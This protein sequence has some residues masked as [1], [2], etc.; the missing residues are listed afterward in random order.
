VRLTLWLAFLIAAPI[1]VAQQQ[2]S[3]VACPIVRDT[4]TVPCFLAEYDGELY[5]L[6]IQ[7]DIN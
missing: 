6:G 4:K 5:Y 1:L 2:R 7:Q 3:F